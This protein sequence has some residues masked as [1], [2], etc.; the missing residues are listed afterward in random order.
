MTSH[1]AALVG[2]LAAFVA[3]GASV[4]VR[5]GGQ[6]TL[7]GLRLANESRSKHAEATLQVSGSPRA[8]SLLVR[9]DKGFAGWLAGLE[10]GDRVEVGPRA[11]L[12]ASG[13]GGIIVLA[14]HASVHVVHAGG[15]GDAP[16]LV[17]LPSGEV[18][19]VRPG[20]AITIAS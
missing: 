9:I 15:D 8:E 7:A 13:E 19:S 16:I 11:V 3:L 6:G 20:V 17:Q 14:S 10:S 12:E 4:E 5:P 1:Y 2:S 18:V